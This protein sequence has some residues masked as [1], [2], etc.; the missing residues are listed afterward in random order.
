MDEFAGKLRARG[1]A[2]TAQRLAVMRAVARQP[3]GTAEEIGAAAR[4]DIGAMSKQAVYD[5]LAVLSAHG[6]IRKIQPAGSVA[7]FE[8]RVGDNHHHMICR[9]CG[10]AWDVDC[11]AG[12]PPCL[13][14]VG[15][16]GFVVDEAEVIYWGRCAGCAG[17]GAS[18][19]GGEKTADGEGGVVDRSDERRGGERR[20]IE[21]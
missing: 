16:A 19:G 5:A 17:A 18:G 4:A 12:K 1:L 6:L 9:V 3:H 20:V 10:E 8:D 21:E 15:A 2:V 13:E 14:P 7:R 11:A